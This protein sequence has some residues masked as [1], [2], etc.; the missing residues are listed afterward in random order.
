M[1]QYLE[2]KDSELEWFGEMPS[3][4]K[5]S[6]CRAI[7]FER[8]I[9]NDKNQS[10]NYLSLMARI[11]VV[12]YEEKGNIGNKKPNDLKK[13]K[14]VNIGDFV[15]N[16]MNYYIGSYGMSEYF[17]ICSP[18]YIVLSPNKSIIEPKFA[19]RIF[20]NS[21]FQKLAQ[22]YGNGIL[23][24]RRMI[25]WDILKNIK[26]PLPPLDM[27]RKI[28]A[29]LDSKVACIDAMIAGKQKMIHLLEES[30]NVIINDVVTKGLDSN[31]KTKNSGIEAIGEIPAHWN[32][33]KLRYLGTCQN[34]LSKGGDSFGSGYPFVSYGDVYKNIELPQN[35]D[36]LVE[37]SDTERANISVLKGDVFFTRTS[38]TIEEVAL[39]STCLHTLENATFSGFLIRF[40]PN[41]EELS[42]NFSKYYF[43]SQLHRAY[44]VKEMNLVTRASLSQDLLKNLPVLLPP[45]NEQENIADFLD[46]K[47]F[48]MNQLRSDSSK[49]IEKL[50]EYRQS[51]I[52]EVV[53]GKVEI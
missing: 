17:G 41:T 46:N 44:F 5:I 8:N 24:H 52:S 12:P 25:N 1:K 28:V 43:R 30:Q 37:S 36:G 22:S 9:R 39:T 47:I 11:G 35:I 49:Q 29:Y 6:S 4:W 51:I 20:E 18:V 7:V 15:I 50:K 26:I 32:L 3:D 23:E 14:I 13:C 21:T 40:R 48:Y 38:E 45:K 10:E 53:T 16:S 42:P 19:F 34:G 2:Y 33:K 27:Q 31:S